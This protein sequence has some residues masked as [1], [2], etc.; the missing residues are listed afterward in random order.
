MRESVMSAEINIEEFNMLL[1]LVVQEK[2]QAKRCARID[3]EENEELH[4]MYSNKSN[5]RIREW[6]RTHKEEARA[7]YK[8]YYKQKRGY[9]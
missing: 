3:W 8:K 2:E 1:D 9:K 7:Y 5:E 6:Q 4:R